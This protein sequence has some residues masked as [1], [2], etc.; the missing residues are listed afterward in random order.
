MTT[1]PAT[2]WWTPPRLAPAGRAPD[3]RAELADLPVRIG[4]GPWPGYEHVY[5]YGVAVLPFDSGHA[6]SLHVFPQND[7]APHKA[8]WHRTPEGAWTIHYDAPH[9]DVACPRYYGAAATVRP[10]R[11]ALRW[12]GP[13]TLKVWMDAP[14]W[15][16]APKLAWTVRM[17]EPPP[18][19]RYNRLNA[20][21]PRWTWRPTP[22]VRTRAWLARRTLGLGPDFAL[23]GSTPS[24]HVGTLMPQRLFPVVHSTARLGGVDLGAPVALAVNPRI[25]DVALPA[26][27]IFAIGGGVWKILDRP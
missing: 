12:V 17:S 18:Y 19:A 13:A 14:A 4:P 2:P 20:A 3:L 5:G 23:S 26:R 22:L 16:D 24:G 21:L 9:P 8:V 25:G 7:F 6:L 11:I 27:P 15:L 10:A 1:I